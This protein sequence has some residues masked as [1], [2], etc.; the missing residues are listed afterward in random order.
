MWL[1][2]GSP[3]PMYRVPVGVFANARTTCALKQVLS[4]LHEREIMAHCFSCSYHRHRMPLRQ[5]CRTV[6][7]VNTLFC[8]QG[9]GLYIKPLGFI[10]KRKHQM[11]TFPRRTSGTSLTIYQN[12]WYNQAQISSHKSARCSSICLAHGVHTAGTE[13]TPMRVLFFI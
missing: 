12:T 2:C 5:L 10:T 3:L 7:L 13:W 4:L 11:S 1:P 6:Y 8:F 9:S